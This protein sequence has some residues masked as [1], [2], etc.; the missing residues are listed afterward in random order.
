MATKR[1]DGVGSKPPPHH[2]PPGCS[3]TLKCFSTLPDHYRRISDHRCKRQACKPRLVSA[4]AGRTHTYKRDMPLGGSCN[5]RGPV[6]ATSELCIFGI[7]VVI[8]VAKTF[9]LSSSCACCITL[10]SRKINAS[11]SQQCKK[12]GCL[13]TKKFE[14]RQRCPLMQSNTAASEPTA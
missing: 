8:I 7:I 5:T 9:K 12:T 1:A 2:T 10:R 3:D 6:E 14:E 4:S 13:A 11:L